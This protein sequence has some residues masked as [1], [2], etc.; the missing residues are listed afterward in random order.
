MRKTPAVILLLLTACM[1]WSGCRGRK[2]HHCGDKLLW[3]EAKSVPGKS[4]W[5]RSEDGK[6][7]RYVEM[8]KDGKAK[9]QVCTYVDGKP[10]G[11]FT[12]WHPDGRTW[13]AGQFR[14]GRISGRW[15]QWD[16]TGSKVAE[17]DYRDGRFIAGAPVAGAAVCDKVQP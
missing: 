16:K 4:M 3:D 6:T 11:S 1:A 15:T 2:S 5:C 12:A 8:H 17:G 14:N 13:I 7:A 9:R 10:E